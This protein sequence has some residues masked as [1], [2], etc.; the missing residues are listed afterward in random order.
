MLWLLRS[1]RQLH[2]FIS[3]ITNVCREKFVL[4]L[5][6]VWIERLSPIKKILLRLFRYI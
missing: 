5:C 6:L 4:C 1:S 2:G 3:Y